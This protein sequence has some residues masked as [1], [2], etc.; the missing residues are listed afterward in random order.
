MGEHEAKIILHNYKQL[1]VSAYIVVGGC[2]LDNR[3][4]KEGGKLSTWAA[5]DARPGP[6]ML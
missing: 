6:Y 2:S 4:C 3:V 5:L 1:H